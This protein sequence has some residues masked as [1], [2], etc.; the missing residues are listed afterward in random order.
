MYRVW[1]RARCVTVVC[2]CVLI[3]AVTYVWYSK[4]M[5]VLTK[6]NVY[7]PLAW[8]LKVPTCESVFVCTSI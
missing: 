1:A 2:M 6:I 7:E 3:R 8:V 5:F 4:D